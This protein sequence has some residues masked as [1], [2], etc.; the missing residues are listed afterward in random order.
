MHISICSFHLRSFACSLQHTAGED[1]G[2]D[3]C[4]EEDDAEEKEEA[5]EEEA[6]EEVA[7]SS[8]KI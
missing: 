7:D 6:E 3:D 2:E 4:K 1:D 8:C 5:E